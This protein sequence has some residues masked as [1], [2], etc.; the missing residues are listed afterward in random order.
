MKNKDITN[1]ALSEGGVNRRKF[2]KRAIQL[3]VAATAAS[4]GIVSALSLLERKFYDQYDYVIVGSGAGGGPLA[5][6][7]VKAG[8]SVLVLEAGSN[9][10]SDDT[11]NI[12]AW[13]PFAS[14]DRKLSWDFFVKHYADINQQMLDD[15]YV[16]GK[17][18][19]YP[20][21]STIGGCTTHHA[22]ITVYP[23]NNDFDRIAQATGD[24]SWDSANMRRYFE[25]LE[26][27]QYLARPIFSNPSRHGFDGWLPTNRGNPALLLED[28][29]VLKIVKAALA[30]YGLEGALQ[31]IVSGNLRL[32]INHWDVA[33]GQEGP[34][35]APMAADSRSRRSSVR[36]HL[37]DTQAIYPNLLH[38]RTDSLA[39]RVLFEGNTAVGVEF[40]EG[41][42]Q[43][44]A[45]PYYDEAASSGVLQQVRA[46]REVILS[47][48]AFNSPQLLKLSGI[49]PAHELR[50]HG[51]DPV[52]DLAGVGENLQDRYEV[53]VV[54]EMS[55]DLALLKDCTW[56]EEGDPCLNRYR[57]GWL[58]KGPYSGNGPVLSLVKRS[59]PDLEDPDL[60]IFGVPSDFHGYFPGYSQALKNYKDRFSWIVLKGHTNNT[61]GRVTLRS[62]DP[63]DTPEINFHY[64]GEGN[65]V[66][67]EDLQAVIEGVKISR[68]IMAGPL[69]SNQISRELLPGSEVQSDQQIGDFVKNQSWGHHAS[70]SN[71]MGPASDPMAVVDSKF[72]V[73][74]TNNLRVVD[75][76]VF[77]RI[78]GFF[79]VVPVYMISEKA[80]DDIIATAV[81]LSA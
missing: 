43:Y 28:P 81:G 65:D 80:S 1:K 2:A 58:N 33:A 31:Q 69:V 32:D 57:Y 26:R 34:F 45:D 22:L 12:P 52:V 42:G 67:G 49:G 5:V 38:I 61:A 27:C 11:H 3:G 37:L 54:S 18:I 21:A 62:A 55:E 56:G 6:N 59:R 29:A 73:H 4:T 36:E 60:F 10:A 14:E 20:R 19:L 64:F 53:G 48:G 40:L 9:D 50:D 25:R 41:A 7:L 66:L 68:D 79:I 15:K 51:I 63:R 24:I 30:R 72:R 39:T 47:G 75:A 76:S 35:I 16:P 71:K 44:K 46:S 8:F 78:P 74:G 13:H 23:H 77:P 70:C 17:G